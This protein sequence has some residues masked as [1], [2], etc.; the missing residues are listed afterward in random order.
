LNAIGTDKGCCAHHKNTDSN[1]FLQNSEMSTSAI[2]WKA[3]QVIAAEEAE[4]RAAALKLEAAAAAAAEEKERTER[5]ARLALQAER[6]L[7]R[8][9][10]ERLLAE[11]QA[12]AARRAESAALKAEIERLR[13]RSE[14]EILRDELANLRAEIAAMRQQTQAL[15]TKQIVQESIYSHLRADGELDMRFRSSKQELSVV[16]QE[17]KELKSVVESLLKGGFRICS[18]YGLAISEVTP[19]GGGSA[20]GLGGQTDV[21]KYEQENLGCRPGEAARHVARQ[22]WFLQPV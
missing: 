7:A 17:V 22:T 15:P 21:A 1:I 12:E 10:A 5:Q 9:Q 19:Y 18:R 16:Q 2:T 4:K 3:M 14:T 8:I 13:N 11:E 20:L 6:E